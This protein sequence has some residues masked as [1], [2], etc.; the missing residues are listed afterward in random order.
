[1]LDLNKLIATGSGWKL[2]SAAGIN[3][4]GQIVGYGLS[5]DGQ[6]HAFL[7]NPIIP[8]PM[9]LAFLGFGG[10]IILRRNSSRGK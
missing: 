8:E 9:T 6:N 2:I 10:L 5:P 7:L 4:M 3:D 1:M